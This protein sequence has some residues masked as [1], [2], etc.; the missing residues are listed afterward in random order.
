[1]LSTDTT[2]LLRAPYHSVEF[3]APYSN[4]AL[5]EKSSCDRYAIAG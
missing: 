3:P 5:S 2:C 1:V 4:T